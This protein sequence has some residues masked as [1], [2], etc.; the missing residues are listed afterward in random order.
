MPVRLSAVLA[1]SLLLSA[2]TARFD[3]DFSPYPTGAQPCLESADKDSGCNGDT[4]PLMNGCLCSTDDSPF[5]EDVARCL[6]RESSSDLKETYRLLEVNCDGSNTPMDITEDEFLALAED[7]EDDEEEPTETSTTTE[8]TPTPTDD[9]EGDDDDGGGLS[10][11][12]TI[13][14]AVAATAVGVSLIAAAIFFFLRRRRI[15]RAADESN[16]MLGPSG[17]G[18]GAHA[19]VPTSTLRDSSYIPPY[20]DSE[21]GKTASGIAAWGPESFNP[22]PPMGQWNGSSG[23]ASWDPHTWGA[24][25][26]AGAAGYAPVGAQAPQQ[27]GMEVYELASTERRP[28]VEMPGSQPGT[29]QP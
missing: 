3:N 12:A 10:S 15:A 9:K 22:T 24:G 26:Q 25:V 2:A 17:P 29:N 19:S 14:I 20:Q 21:V 7:D 18:P 27:G 16:P 8:P 28:V 23:P 6:K 5:L 11:G 1:A 4:V 13:G